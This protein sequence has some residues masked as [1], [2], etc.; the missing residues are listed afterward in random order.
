MIHLEPFKIKYGQFQ[1]FIQ[2]LNQAAL[3]QRKRHKIGHL[4][5][6]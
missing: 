1:S 5:T 6:I 2:G 3:Y 4:S